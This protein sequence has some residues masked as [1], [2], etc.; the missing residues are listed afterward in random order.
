[1]GSPDCHTTYEA[2]TV[3]ISLEGASIKTYHELVP[4]DRVEIVRKDVFPYAI[5]TRVVWVRPKDS[6]GA[7]YFAG[8]QFLDTPPV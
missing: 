6:L 8:L 4:G 5:P 3:D 2:S 1:M 7:F